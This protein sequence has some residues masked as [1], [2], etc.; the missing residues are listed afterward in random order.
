MNPRESC[1]TRLKPDKRFR[2][3]KIKLLLSLL[4]AQFVFTA[5]PSMEE[6]VIPEL[7]LMTSSM[8]MDDPKSASVDL[9]FIATHPWTAEVTDGSDWMKVSPTSGSGADSCQVV[10][11]TVKENKD[12]DV[13]TGTVAI[14]MDG[15][16]SK[17]LTLTQPAAEGEFEL[18]DSELTFDAA[19][20]EKMVTIYAPDSWTVEMKSSLKGWIEVSP[21][22]GRAT[23]TGREVTIYV[24][25]NDGEERKGVIS[26]VLGDDSETLDLKIVQKNKEEEKEDVTQSL[27]LSQEEVTLEAAG[28]DVIV[29]VT[30]TCDWT[31]TFDET[32]DWLVVDPASGAAST[33]A[34]KVTVSALSNEGYDR[35]VSVEFSIGMQTKYLTVKQAGSKGSADALVIYSNNYDKEVAAKTYGSGTAWPYLDQFD[36]WKNQKGTGA[37]NVTYAFSEMSARANSTSNSSYSDYPGS[38][39]NNMFFGKSAYL[40]TNNIDLCGAT[41]LELTFGAEKYSQDNGS[42]FKNEEF[43]IWL[44]ADGGAKWVELTDYTFAGGTTEGRWNVA[45]A[46]FSVP[47]GTAALSICMAVDVPSSYRM[48]DLMLMTSSEVGTS[49]DFSQAVAKDFGAGSTGGDNTGGD[50]T[51][52]EVTPP[53]EAIFFESFASGKGDFTI[54]DKVLPAGLTYVWSED[55]QYRNMKAS[56]FKDNVKYAA[57]S[58]LISPEIDLSSATAADL[59]FEHTGKYFGTMADE[60]TVYARKAGGEWVKLTIPTYMSGSDWVFVSSGAIDLKDYVG[61]KMQFAFKYVSTSN[62]AG[63]WEIKNVCVSATSEST[64][65]NTGGDA[66]TVG[67]ME[68]PAMDDRSLSYYSHSFK[69][70]NDGKTYRNYS[71][72]WSQDDLVAVWVAYPLCKFYTNKTV[73][74]TNA[75]AYDPLL[76]SAYSS[77]PFSGYGGDYARGHQL[78][79]A[80]RL[81]CTEANKQ[82]FYG[83]NL[84]PQLNEHNEGIWQALEDRVRT[85]ANNSDTTYVVTGCLVTNPIGTTTDSDGKKMSVP[86]HYFKALLRYSK[87]STLGQWSAAGFY[88]EHRN[89][90]KGSSGYDFKA[91]SM[92]ID[93]LEEKTGL[94]FF[95]N[96]PAKIGEDAAARLEAQD[97]VSSSVWW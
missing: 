41:D 26:F 83:T 47:A 11:I 18:S 96:L 9:E 89:Y 90:S 15:V 97:P 38:G 78:P 24:K 58:W 88:L 93:E 8:E 50:N 80:D 52:G 1:S 45:A 69:Y 53:T 79:S 22:K 34:Q 12:S 77:A 57:E 13:R 91:V 30:A 82:T 86:S 44:S 61:G 35:E 72:G 64:G 7:R 17:T 19:G 14:S 29:E 74:R 85:I 70:P 81:C 2:M 55:T 56:A 84:T 28:G 43:H 40:A 94:D 59:L 16:E 87:A 27:I 31:V 25:P 51:G 32:A 3:K 39:N 36:G 92:S 73:D 54:E 4:I 60:A 20:G 66:G 75:W 68:L 48:D 46:N 42:L 65:G 21:E 10:I 49:V 95:V 23:D 33:D 67:W 5:C 63:T 6:Q 62:A 37:A 76:G 71:F